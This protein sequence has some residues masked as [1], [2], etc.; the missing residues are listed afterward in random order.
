MM[1]ESARR[2]QRARR[3][4]VRRRRHRRD[5]PWIARARVVARAL[6]PTYLHH[7]QYVDQLCVLLRHLSQERALEDAHVDAL[8]DVAFRPSDAFEE[9]RKNVSA[10]RRRGGQGLQRRAAGR[11][12][13]PRSSASSGR[14]APGARVRSRI[15][16]AFRRRGGGDELLE[17]VQRLAKGDLAGAMAERTLLLPRRRRPSRRAAPTRPAADSRSEKKH[18][19][20]R[21]CFAARGAD[22]RA[23][24]R[25]S[26]RGAFA[27]A[28]E[29][30]DCAGI[31]T[32]SVERGRAGARGAPSERTGGVAAAASRRSA[33]SLRGRARARD[34]DRSSRSRDAMRHARVCP[35]RGAEEEGPRKRRA[36]M[37]REASAAEARGASAS[38]RIPRA[39]ASDA[40]TPTRR[41]SPR[42]SGAPKNRNRNRSRRRDRSSPAREASGRPTIRTAAARWLRSWTRRC[43]C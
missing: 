41:S 20:P 9:T 28:L 43:S 4:R 26:H 3:R 30:Y 31:E 22:R 13:P 29:H 38:S 36:E 25:A 11:V 5:L 33:Q 42:S 6:R 12:V 23:A 40:A 27:R 24:R 8:W 10:R 21:T 35:L 14:R 1:L 19:R 16:R 32:A 2:R 15:R 39:L 17:M 7:K 18:S 34:A 37:E